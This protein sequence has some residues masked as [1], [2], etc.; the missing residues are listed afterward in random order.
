M[1]EET[2]WR[3]LSDYLV[4]GAP[5]SL[6]VVVDSRGSS[7]ARPGAKLVVGQDGALVGTIGGGAIEHRLVDQTRR[8]LHGANRPVSLIH[9]RHNPVAE[10]PRSGMICGGSQAVAI[11]RC[12]ETDLSTLSAILAALERRQSGLLQLGPDGL[13]FIPAADAPLAPPRFC[14]DGDGGWHYEEVL[15]RHPTAFL[16]GGGHV[17]LALSRILALL[18]FRIVVLEE[19]PHL[20]T[21]ADN[22]D[23]HE[24]RIVDYRSL[25]DHVPAGDQH[26]AIIMTHG[27]RHDE[28]VLRQLLGK[29]LCYLGMLGSRAKVTEIMTRLATEFPDEQL[30]R[31][32]APIGLPIGSHTPPEIAVSIAAEMILA[33][34]GAVQ[35]ERN[36]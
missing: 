8:S 30:R 10:G 5:V 12:R 16:I 34:N 25:A 9:Q 17:S 1:V 7:P 18:S 26:Y 35:N 33:K 23:A 19:R 13:R 3:C 20:A 31:V 11:Y 36:P 14:Q 6:L 2:I 22:L 32:H 29:P 4:R 28:R 21:L 27:H 24:K 15:G